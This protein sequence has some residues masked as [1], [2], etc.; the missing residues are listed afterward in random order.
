MASEH[1]ALPG[2]SSVVALSYAGGN[3]DLRRARLVRERQSRETADRMERTQS[4]DVDASTWASEHRRKVRGRH[5]RRDT[6]PDHRFIEEVRDASREQKEQTYSDWVEETEPEQEQQQEQEQEPPRATQFKRRDHGHDLGPLHI[7]T[8]GN[9]GQLGRRNSRG[10]RYQHVG[11]RIPQRERL[12]PNSLHRLLPE[13]WGQGKRTRAI[14]RYKKD[15][16]QAE[17][18]LQQLHFNEQPGGLHDTGSG[19]LVTSTPATPMRSSSPPSPTPTSSLSSALKRKTPAN[20]SPASRV[21]E[22]PF[23]KP[24]KSANLQNKSGAPED[25]IGPYAIPVLRDARVP[26]TQA[27]RQQPRAQD[28]SSDESSAE[29]SGGTREMGAGRRA[30]SPTAPDRKSKFPVVTCVAVDEN[31]DFPRSELAAMA[32]NISRLIDDIDRLD[33][34]RRNMMDELKVL[35][36]VTL[37]YNEA[38]PEL[39]AAAKKPV[40]STQVTRFTGFAWPGYTRLVFS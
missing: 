1:L 26:K 27:A 32:K 15:L 4:Q 37:F 19:P 28:Y 30:M 7:S 17:E 35:R 3:D 40:P 16:R 12:P 23:R 13:Y 29:S 18:E 11:Q 24:A 25:T 36:D 39:R 8:R 10:G 34:N 33:I 20:P 6:G 31:Y 9:R 38:D 5:G 2:S 14:N 21:P 22:R